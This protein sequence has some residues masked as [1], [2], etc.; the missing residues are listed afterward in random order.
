MQS[1]MATAHLK[2]VA[3]LALTAKPGLQR[4]LR[5]ARQPGRV[6]DRNPVGVEPAPSLGFGQIV[7]Q[8]IE[9]ALDDL[10]ATAQI[11]EAAQARAEKCGD[12]VRQ[13]GSRPRA[14]FSA[15]KP[16]ARCWAHEA[17][18]LI[19]E[20]LAKASSVRP[21]FHGRAAAMSRRRVHY[22]PEKRSMSKGGA[23]LVPYRA[24]P[25]KANPRKA[26]VLRLNAGSMLWRS[27]AV[28][29]PY[30][31]PKGQCFLY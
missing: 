24:A 28:L 19:G 23:E 13:R 22:R 30:Y 6:L 18:K 16:G 29:V 27:G 11:V 5:E 15:W 3:S 21:A 10:E 1:T 12:L 31:S 26:F 7:A 9:A 20:T 17:R 8:I 4:D 2:P 14:E 25:E